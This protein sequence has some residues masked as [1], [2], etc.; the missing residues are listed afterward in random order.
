MSKPIRPTRAP[1]GAAP[2][3]PT[4]RAE[5]HRRGAS[6]RG[7]LRATLAGAA[8]V[9]AAAG[10]GAMTGCMGAP[11]R[12]SYPQK[13]LLTVT[14]GFERTVTFSGCGAAV[15]RQGF[16]AVGVTTRNADLVNRLRTRASQVELRR[17]LAKALSPA[18]CHHTTLA[19]FL[20][21]V[22]RVL[23]DEVIRWYHTAAGVTIP[24]DSLSVKLKTA[25]PPAPPPRRAIATD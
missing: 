11:R 17:R 13:R 15:E 10:A 18:A 25:V 21:R 19:S 8:G 5:W 7:F 24:S 3:Y 20:A 22:E 23:R 9:A 2:S 16:M 14:I 4:L 6:R 1:D 12:P